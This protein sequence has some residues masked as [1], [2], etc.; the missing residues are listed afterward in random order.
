MRFELRPK[1]VHVFIHDVFPSGQLEESHTDSTVEQTV[2]EHDEDGLENGAERKGVEQDLGRV[3]GRQNSQDPN[4]GRDRKQSQTEPDERPQIAVA[5]DV[6]FQSEGGSQTQ[7]EGEERAADH[8]AT[9]SHQ[10]PDDGL[11]DRQPATV[12]TSINHDPLHGN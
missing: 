10:T 5:F 8:E 2:S 1:A 4:G 12:K 7:S 11:K 3:A 9:R 6:I